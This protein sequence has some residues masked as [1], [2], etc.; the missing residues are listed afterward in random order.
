MLG[1]NYHGHINLETQARI[2]LASKL[3]GKSNVKC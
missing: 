1:L 3:A 2:L